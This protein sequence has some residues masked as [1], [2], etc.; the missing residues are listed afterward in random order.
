VVELVRRRF[1]KD[2]VGLLGHSWGM[3]LGTIYAHHY[4]QKVAA[5]VG[6]AQIA[7]MAEGARLSYEFALS[8][9]TKRGHRRAI[10]ALQALGPSPD[11]VAERLTVG[12]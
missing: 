12:K 10:A 5:Y 3:V 11:L 1:D 9:A 2:R 6:I 7:D 4:P 8:E